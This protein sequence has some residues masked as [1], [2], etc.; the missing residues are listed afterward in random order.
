METEERETDPNGRNHRV[1]A[2]RVVRWWE[3]GVEALGAAIVY[4]VIVL[5]VAGAVAVACLVT[6]AVLPWL[7]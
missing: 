4:G 7:S 5:V 3:P 1:A 6:T 2:D